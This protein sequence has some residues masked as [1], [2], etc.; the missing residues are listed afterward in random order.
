MT[1]AALAVAGL[2]MTGPALAAQDRFQAC[3]QDNDGKVTWQEF[4]KAYPKPEEAKEAF[5]WYDRNGDGEIS[6]KE[7]DAAM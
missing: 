4:Q 2:M 5:Q 3:D 1:V 7:M 6:Q